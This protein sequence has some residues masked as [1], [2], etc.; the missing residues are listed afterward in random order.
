MLTLLTRYRHDW[1]TALKEFWPKNIRSRAQSTATLRSHSWGVFRREVSKRPHNTTPYEE[2]VK[3]DEVQFKT[4]N[5]GFR[6]VELHFKI[7]EIHFKTTEQQIKK[8]GNQ[9]KKDGSQFK[10]AEVQFKT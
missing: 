7:I 2:Q 3:T 10:T 4:N 8:T 5:V 9:F 6:T 1:R